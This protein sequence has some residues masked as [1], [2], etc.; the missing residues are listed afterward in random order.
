MEFGDSVGGLGDRP[1]GFTDRTI[2]VGVVVLG[3]VVLGFVEFTVA[4]VGFGFTVVF[5]ECGF[6]LEDALGDSV[7]I[8]GLRVLAKDS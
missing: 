1:S 2:T 3:F 7:G 4:F 5:V 8:V 6:T